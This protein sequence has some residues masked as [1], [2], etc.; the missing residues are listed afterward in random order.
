MSD[1][2]K[3][4]ERPLTRAW[5][6]RRRLVVAA[7]CVALL[8]ITLGSALAIGAQSRTESAPRAL[9]T[10]TASPAPTPTPTATPEPEGGELP[11][12]ATARA[13]IAAWHV[14]GD[15]ELAAVLPQVGG[16]SDGSI[17]LMIDAPAVAQPTVAAYVPVAV[18][19]LTEY[20]VSFDVRLLSEEV[21]ATPVELA[22]GSTVVKMPELGA[23]WWT[24][25]RTVR[26]GAEQAALDLKLTVADDVRG[27]AIDNIVMVAKEGT[28]VVPNGSFEDV[29][30]EWGIVNDSLILNEAMATLAAS[31][32]PGEATWVANRPDGSEAARGRALI[33]GSVSPIPLE[34]LSQGYY[35]LHVTDATGATLTAPVGV[36]RM[37][38]AFLSPDA[39][40]GA[41][42][43]PTK[44]FNIDGVSAA[45]SVGMGNLRINFTWQYVEKQRGVYTWGKTYP[46]AVAQATARDIGVLGIAGW[47]NPLYGGVP[48]TQDALAGY[49]RYAAA[50][51]QQ[52]PLVGL[53]VFN[54][55]NIET[56]NKG[57]RTG[58]CY[59][60][61]VQAVYGPVKSAAPD[62]PVIGGVTG[63]YD[64]GFFDQLWQGGGLQHVD[65][66]SFHPY[67][68]YG[69]PERLNSVIRDARA[70]MDANGGSKPIWITEL[71]WT[72]KTGDV[73]LQEQGNR[74]V[75]AQSTALAEGVAHYFWYDLINDETDPAAHEG[76]FGLFEQ[77]RSGLAA[78]PPKPAAFV[79]ALWLAQLDGREFAAVDPIDGVRSVSFGE[80]GDTMK[81]AYPTAGATTAEF[82]AW[83]TVTATD[84]AGNVEEIEPRGG[85]V[86]IELDRILLLGG[87]VG[88]SADDAGGDDG[89]RRHDE[90]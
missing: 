70:S 39:R 44:P 34:G 38:R 56:F 71:G 1:R 73:S 57:C 72:T 27:F 17:A 3:W 10:P 74:L 41:H 85:T 14:A 30:S 81:V 47:G 54:E 25:T 2:Q 53:E 83:D 23:E 32:A 66:M 86:T 24:I 75:R 79:Q 19:P 48:T 22:V 31:V 64:A 21:A 35:E 13:K 65:A 55:F 84:L 62:V 59:L 45:S 87:G 88:E 46:R 82:P 5:W 26:T 15:T 58:A 20:T 36:V 76:N 18:Q 49:G 7:A 9:L 37:P 29:S 89:A 68:V 61:L 43:H 16:A 12:A 40:I 52:F 51:A 78:L 50:V 63:N 11:R 8:V 90:P 33:S 4:W 67:Q 6:T 42:F 77:P 69:A 80:P 28:N 60:P